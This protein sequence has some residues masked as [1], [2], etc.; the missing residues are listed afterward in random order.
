MPSVIFHIA[1]AILIITGIFEE[2]LN[3]KT[4]FLVI[5]VIMV[6][7]LDALTEI[8]WLGTHRTLLHNLYIPLILSIIFIYD[9]YIRDNSYIQKNWGIYG[10]KLT[11]VIIFCLTFVSIGLDLFYNGVNLFWPIYDQFFILNGPIYYSTEEGLKLALFE[12]E[13]AGPTSEVHLRTGFDMVQG[14]DPPNI[15]RI[16]VLFGT[17]NQFLISVL[18]FII[19]TWKL[20]KK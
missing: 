8:F 2:K 15:E 16:F 20:S 6:P 3:L 18:A 19:V 1:I 11:I 14:T 10:K 12:I 4:I 13:K 7:D 9:F 17:G 5:A